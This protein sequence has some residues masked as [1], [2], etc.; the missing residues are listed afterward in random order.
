MAKGMCSG[1]GKKSKKM[2]T[3]SSDVIG[4]APIP[5]EAVTSGVKGRIL[6]KSSEKV[7]AKLKLS[8][9]K[10]NYVSFFVAD[11]AQL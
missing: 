10:G 1:A 11:G 2:K 7:L 8:R 3:H 5:T 6:S 4:R 9:I